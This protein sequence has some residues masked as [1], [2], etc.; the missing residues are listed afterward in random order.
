[1]RKSETLFVIGRIIS[2][3]IAIFGALILAFELRMNY[4]ELLNLQSPTPFI[5]EEFCSLA[6]KI[7]LVLLLV[8][9]INGR[10]RFYVDEKIW[11]EI[12]YIFWSFSSGMAFLVVIFFFAQFQFFSRFIFGLAWALGLVMI[13]LF[14]MLL[15]GARRILY[16]KKLGQS[17]IIVLGN[18]KLARDAI[19]EIARN[20]KYNLLGVLT[21]TSSKNKHFAE[22]DILGNFDSFEKVLQE[23][24]PNEVLLAHDSPTEKL[25]PKLVRIAH[26]NHVNFRFLPDEL[27]LDLAAVTVSTFGKF[28]LVT[29]V[30]N[31][32]HGWGALVKSFF[33]YLLSLLAIIILSPIF[34]FVALRIWLQK[35]GAIVYAS[36]R[37][38]K[39]GKHFNCYKF[40]SMVVDAEKKKKELLNKNERSDG[41]LFKMENDPRITP[42]GQ[43]IRKWSLDELPQFF[44]VLKGDMSLIGPRPHLPEEVKKYAADD[45]RILSIKPGMTGFSQ[46]NGRSSLRFEDEVNF[47]LFY[48]KNWNLW[49][50]LVIFFKT[51][52]VVLRKENVA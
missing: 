32:I 39:N 2:D 35:D 10:Y 48:A 27:G 17:K 28:P 38:G 37:V 26:I 11:E 6:L 16:Y 24:K 12:W 13:V 19:D 22:A 33:D 9:A 50:D 14:R 41:V 23:F 31:K 3:G 52:W 47:E 8:L 40:R 21:E 36:K 46:I 30:A 1:M 45:L 29:L 4:Y 20:P 44:N 49:L 18:G 42:F 34:L 51:I 25:T 15:R 5:F 43:F 7:A